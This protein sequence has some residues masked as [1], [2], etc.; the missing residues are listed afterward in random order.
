MSWS[1][2]SIIVCLMTGYL[3]IMGATL[4]YIE[5]RN[6]D[7]SCDEKCKTMGSLLWWIYWPSRA[8]YL[9]IRK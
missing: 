4:G 1:K 9:I 8:G 5:N 3:F 7:G 2:G 6:F